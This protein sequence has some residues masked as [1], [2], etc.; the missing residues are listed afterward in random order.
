MSEIAKDITS[1]VE[2][3]VLSLQFEDICTQPLGAAANTISALM[4]MNSDLKAMQSQG[5]NSQ[6]AS[7]LEQLI[8]RLRGLK[9]YIE[10]Q[11][12]QLAHRHKAVTAQSMA[13][14]DVDIF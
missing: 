12:G 1:S 9:D 5:D 8:E 6:D 10:K 11:R 2:I 14:G 3:A 7:T 4:G 13:S